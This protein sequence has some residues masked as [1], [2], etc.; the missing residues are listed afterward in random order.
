VRCLCLCL[1]DRRVAGVQPAAEDLVARM[2]EATSEA[3]LPAYR[4]AHAGYGTCTWRAKSVRFIRSYVKSYEAKYLSSVFRKGVVVYA[5]PARTQGAYASSR[6]SGGERW[7]RAA[8]TDEGCG[9]RTAKA[10]GPDLPTLGSTLGVQELGLL[11]RGDGGY[12][13]RYTGYSI[14]TFLSLKV[15][16][17]LMRRKASRPRRITFGPGFP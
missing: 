10:C 7:T 9:R 14:H 11:T 16:P 12:Q 15:V 5:H 13:A 17:Y 3:A 1:Y 4:F 8:S 2:S 6:T